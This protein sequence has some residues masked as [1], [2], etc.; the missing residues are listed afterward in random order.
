MT[1]V[2]WV[3]ENPK[4][5]EELLLTAASA[6]NITEANGQE[7]TPQ[8]ELPENIQLHMAGRIVDLQATG[9]LGGQLASKI[10]ARTEA[11]FKH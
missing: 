5:L 6:L 8:N 3:S 9:D 7:L 4:N 10:P 1:C 2:A 11:N